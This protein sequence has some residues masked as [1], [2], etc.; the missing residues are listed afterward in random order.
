MRDLDRDIRTCANIACQQP[1]TGPEFVLQVSSAH[2]RWF[3]GVDCVVEGQQVLHRILGEVEFG[4]G[5]LVPES[6][7]EFSDAFWA[8]AHALGYRVPVA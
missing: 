1:V 2:L 8:T 4:P 6:A 3:C 7:E 5:S